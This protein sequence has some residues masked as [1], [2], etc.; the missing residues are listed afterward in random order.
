MEQLTF[1]EAVERLGGTRAPAQ[2][3]PAAV[4][5]VRYRPVPSRR[6]V[7]WGPDEYRVAAAATELYANRLLE[8]AAALDYMVGRGFP[9]S[10]LERSRVGYCAGDQLLKYLGWRKLPIGAALRAGLLT[11]DG[12]EF[13][14]G[15]IV[16]PEIRAGR[17]IWL[18]G[19]VLEGGA[20][21]PAAA[22]PRYLGLP[23][24]SP[25]SAG[26][27]PIGICA[28]CASWKARPTCWPSP[29]GACPGWLSVGPR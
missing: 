20:A 28:A 16:F 21:E 29:P 10:L 17:V 18:I 1:R 24:G 14:A 6:G 11:D 8:D 15:R 27:R 22:D 23:V 25:S 3:A 19:R 26:R 7:V 12:R 4:R 5:P 2:G 9:R 13:L